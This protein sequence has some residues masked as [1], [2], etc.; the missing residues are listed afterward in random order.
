MGRNRI[1][2]TDGNDVL[3]GTTL[4]DEIRG[5]RGDDTLNGFE[6]DDRLRG[7]KGNDTLNGDIGNDRLI[8]GSGNDTLN[9]GDGNDRLKGGAGDDELTGGSGRD[10]FKFDLRGGTDTI[11]D[12]VDG[13]DRLDFTNFSI[14]PT[15]T[16]SAFEVLMSHAEQAGNDVV[17]TMD[18]GEMMIIQNTLITDFDAGDFRI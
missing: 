7:E 6:G 10:Q 3:D 11:T 9:G 16:Q 15:A 5:G 12:Y 13:E 18:G 14:A 1:D 2:G 4:D 8:G 17:F